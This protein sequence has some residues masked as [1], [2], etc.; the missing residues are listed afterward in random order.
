M[1]APGCCARVRL[2]PRTSGVAV[3]CRVLHNI[4][5]GSINERCRR[6]PRPAPVLHHAKCLYAGLGLELGL[7]LTLAKT[8]DALA[9]AAAKAS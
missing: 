8:F 4:L 2:Y 9:M 6:G 7:G 3:G 1:C 5:S